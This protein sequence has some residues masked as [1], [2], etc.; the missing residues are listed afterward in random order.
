MGVS[1]IS[2]CMISRRN[3]E[4]TSRIKREKGSGQLKEKLTVIREEAKARI[5]V[6][7]LPSVILHTRYDV[8]QIREKQS[9]KLSEKLRKLSLE[10]DRPLFEVTNTVICYDLNIKPPK[11]VM[12]TL[13]LGPKNVV[14]EKLNDFQVLSETDYLLEYCKRTAVDEDTMTDINVKTLAYRNRLEHA[15]N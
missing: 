3:Y 12:E 13:S 11:Y 2:Q 1:T 10:Q 14:L 6:K 8:H 9:I 15:V 4:G 7:C 5:P